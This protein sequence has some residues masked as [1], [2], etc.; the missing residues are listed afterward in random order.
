[1]IRTT[2]S[3]LLMLMI[4][5]SVNAMELPATFKDMIV[6]T[7]KACASAPD[8]IS[9]FWPVGRDHGKKETEDSC[10]EFNCDD[11][12]SLFFQR[13]YVE[14]CWIADSL[15][16]LLPVDI[17]GIISYYTLYDVIVNH[18]SKEV[19]LEQSL[20]NLIGYF[21]GAL[22]LRKIRCMRKQLQ[23]F[24]FDLFGM[25]CLEKIINRSHLSLLYADQRVAFA[26]M[27]GAQINMRL[28]QK[29]IDHGWEDQAA[30]ALDT[31]LELGV[32]DV[33]M[34]HMLYQ[35][36]AKV[37]LNKK[38]MG[39]LNTTVLM[40]T[41]Y[42]G[43]L[44][45]KRYINADSIKDT[46]RLGRTVLHYAVMSAN[47]CSEKYLAYSIYTL[48]GHNVAID[49]VDMYKKSPFDL[50][51][52]KARDLLIAA[53]TLKEY[54][55]QHS[56]IR[57]LQQMSQEVERPLKEEDIRSVMAIEV[58]CRLIQERDARVERFLK[59]SNWPR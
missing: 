33:D 37:G 47:K 59:E 4:C 45:F 56:Y 28:F 5:Y 24:M 15:L 27:L 30:A 20:L 22:P 2:N 53:M 8:I 3:L 14:P 16:S 38:L 54:L 48:L 34:R 31:Y 51:K 36:V 50:A 40:E 18:F 21:N 35:W 19:G 42:N 55:D 7:A 12:A 26:I 57:V 58:L 43:S 25:D 9:R 23:L 1:M 29:L 10:R 39:Y 13:R 11:E 44:D 49:Q 46:D 17:I 32:A 41:V 52:G 6:N